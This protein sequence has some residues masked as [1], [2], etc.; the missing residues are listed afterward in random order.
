MRMVVA[1]AL[2]AVAGMMFASGAIGL[3]MISFMGACWLV[4]SRPSAP[5]NREE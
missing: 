5:T 4:I 3:G 1:G 2:F